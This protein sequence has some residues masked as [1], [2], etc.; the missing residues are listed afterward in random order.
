MNNEINKQTNQQTTNNK[1]TICR[2]L[3]KYNLNVKFFFR[4]SPGK[5]TKKIFNVDEW[6]NE[7]TNV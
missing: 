2:L 1:Q 5:R 6:T 3:F 7:Q 4:C